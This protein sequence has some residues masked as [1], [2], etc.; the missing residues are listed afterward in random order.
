ML[1]TLLKFFIKF[2]LFVKELILLAFPTSLL[3]SSFLLFSYPCFRCSCQLFSLSRYSFFLYGAL[4]FTYILSPLTFSQF[5]FSYI[6]CFQS[7]TWYLFFSFIIYLVILNPNS[8]YFR[9]SVLTVF[10]F[11]C[12]NSSCKLF[13][14]LY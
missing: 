6:V 8:N 5:S 4:L 2:F 7:L 3:W 1:I 13:F 9:S 12:R 11:S 14:Y 10:V